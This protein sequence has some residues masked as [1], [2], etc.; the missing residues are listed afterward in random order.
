MLRVQ[1]AMA[2]STELK[3]AYE[4][5]EGM[6]NGMPTTCMDGVIPAT[7]DHGQVI[8]NANQ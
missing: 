6:P 4:A 2:E 3:D 8:E 1:R 5:R 7:H